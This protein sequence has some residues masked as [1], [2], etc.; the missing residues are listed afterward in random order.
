MK[1]KGLIISTVVMVVVLIASL[2]TA[3]YAWFTTSASTSISGFDVS[4]V[5]GNVMNIGLNAENY[6]SYSPGASPDNFVSGACTYVDDTTSGLFGGG[7]W[8]GE[9]ESLG[10]TITHN[11]N[12]GEQDMAVGFSTDDG[13][14]TDVTKATFANTG[15]ISAASWKR[16]IKANGDATKFKGNPEYA[17]ANGATGGDK[18]DFV[19][20]F[21]G[22][23]AT[24]QIQ[25]D[26]NYLYVVIQSQGSGT[27]N[28]IASAIHVAYKLNGATSW[29]DVDYSTKAATNHG[30]YSQS[31][32]E[33]TAVIYGNYASAPGFQNGTYSDTTKQTT[34]TGAVA[35]PIKLSNWDTTNGAALD[36]IQLV[37]YLAGSDEDCI[38]AAKNGS[39]KIGIFFGAQ[40]VE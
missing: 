24:K 40:A 36:Q 9:V 1:K 26:T 16:A 22:A 13:V 39:V 3:T 2:T 23:Q 20:M 25:D 33:N 21:L 28:G 30:K 34:F 15:L 19:Y 27:T 8:T 31:R 4:V 32:A 17:N 11:I 18:G 38:D 37:I 7:Y 14:D 35:V 29:T 12:W 5:A 6:T 10:S